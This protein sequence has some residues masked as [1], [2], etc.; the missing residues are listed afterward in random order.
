MASLFLIRH[1]EPEITGVLL[2][3]MDPALAPAGKAQLAATLRDV[4]VEVAWTSPLRRARET[5]GYVQ[6]RRVIEL[7]ELREIDQGQWTGKSWA[8]IEAKWGDL[9]S[10]KMS[11]WLAV[12]APGGETW[13]TFLDRV[14]HAW[15]VIRNGPRPAAV[16]AHQ[17]VN[18]AL[19]YLIDGRNP[20]DFAQQYGEVI[21]L[22]YD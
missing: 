18:A 1:G 13:S 17:G 4:Q 10:R 12:A 14:R 7:P 8:E 22:E 6:A 9:A 11:N 2:G 21:E 5:S 16:V 19:R 15:S 20:L 3:Q